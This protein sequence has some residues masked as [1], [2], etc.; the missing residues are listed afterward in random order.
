MD[1]GLSGRKFGVEIECL[2][3]DS[4]LILADAL[5]ESGIRAMPDEWGKG[6]Y[7]CWRVIP[8]S[9][10]FGYWYENLSS[11][12]VI[13]PPLT[14]ESGLGELRTVL[15]TLEAEG[16][17]TNS[18]CGIHVHHD[19]KGE[20]PRCIRNIARFYEEFEETIGGF[21]SPHRRADGAANEYCYSFRGAW[22]LNDW[23]VSDNL[24]YD[25]RGRQ[26]VVNMQNIQ[27]EYGTV[28][29]RQL[30]S[31]LNYNQ[32]ASW[33]AFTQA[34]V[35]SASCGRID[36]KG[37]LRNLGERRLFQLTL[38]KPD[39]ARCLH[40]RAT[41]WATTPLERIVTEDD[42]E[43]PY[44]YDDEDDIGE[45]VRVV[46][47]EIPNYYYTLCNCPHCVQVRSALRTQT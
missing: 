16:V 47:N 9:S 28:E 15:E 18:T 2:T 21:V 19:V 24:G 25:W 8:D 41:Y 7:P 29:F 40:E 1:F 22:W 12:E 43:E 45:M 13:S 33:I 6:V 39:V 20:S 32:V 23:Y 30:D 34:I 38:V 11:A 17:R 4:R 27:S 5:Q 46:L 36:I 10:V 14:G 42:A 31:T 26:A 3:P 44:D 37:K 35:D